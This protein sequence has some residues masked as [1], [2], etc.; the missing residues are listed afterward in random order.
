M[1]N[2]WE[3]EE[4][5][6]VLIRNIWL[7]YMQS[8]FETQVGVRCCGTKKLEYVG[9]ERAGTCLLQSINA[10]SEQVIFRHLKI[11]SWELGVEGNAV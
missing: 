4:F 5:N 3:C 8:R 11:E 9:M 1:S 7:T 2:T 10:V 6:E